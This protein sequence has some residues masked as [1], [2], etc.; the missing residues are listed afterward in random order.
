MYTTHTYTCR[1]ISTADLALYDILCTER[2]VTRERKRDK[3]RDRSKENGDGER[4]KR[5]KEK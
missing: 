1:L 5:R 3:D 2:E 4:K